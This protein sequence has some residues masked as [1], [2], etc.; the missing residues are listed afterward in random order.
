MSEN[1]I[2]CNSHD[3]IFLTSKGQYNILKCLTCG[4]IWSLPMKPLDDYSQEITHDRYEFD[5]MVN[6]LNR[7]NLHNLKVFELGCGDGRFLCKLKGLGADVY[8]IDINANGIAKAKECG[9]ENVFTATLTKDFAEQF[10]KS[11]DLIFAFHVLEHIE[12]IDNIKEVIRNINI[13]LKP[14][15]FLFLSVPNPERLSARIFK[16]SWDEPPYHLT[17]WTKKSLRLLLE[18]NGFEILNFVEEPLNLKSAYIY[19]V[20][21]QN[22]IINSFFLKLKKI[23][24]SG[25]LSKGDNINKTKFNYNK[26]KI[27]KKFSHFLIMTISYAVGYTIYFFFSIFS[28]IENFTEKSE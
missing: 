17:K 14:G 10:E 25:S 26:I 12:H 6:F 27:I 16:E 19:V 7:K 3:R 4:L 9:L 28:T 21:I 11:F 20:D 22:I 5:I 24:N 23:A 8:G 1:C 2:V 15:G 13:M 18:N